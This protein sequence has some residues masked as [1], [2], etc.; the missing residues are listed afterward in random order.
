MII[1]DQQIIYTNKARCRDCFRCLRYCTVNAIKMKDGQAFV[2]IERCILCG[3]CI[4]ECPQNAKQFRRDLEKVKELIKE[5]MSIAV[6]IAPSFA[7]LF[8]DWQTDRIPSLLRKLGFTY[9][10]ETAESAYYTAIETEKY[11]S[12]KS[13]GICL[14]TA[15][16]SFVDYV[17]KYL[18]DKVNNL[19][20][21]V[22]PMIAHGRRIKEK[23]GNQT[24]VVFIGPC[25]AKKR[26]AERQE[27]NGIIDAVLTFTEVLEWIEEEKIDLKMLETS[28]FDE[29]V[30]GEARLYPLTGGMSK[31]ASLATDNLNTSVYSISGLERI[32]DA[33]SSFSTK[34]YP[35]LIEPLI[36]A[37]G[38]VNGPAQPKAENIF[39]RR[40]SVINYSK[41][42][43]CISL[44]IPECTINLST[45]FK[46]NAAVKETEF[47][48]EEI[49]QILDQ[50]GKL[51]ESDR[52][53]CGACGYLSCMENAKAI[54]MGMVEIDSCIPYTRRLVLFRFL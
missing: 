26:E 48:D 36:C 30:F 42:K 8:T 18:P 23:L 19:T 6:S 9:I 34:D 16:P 24:K 2:D 53:N 29:I 17:E 1:N 40:E 28:E 7:A 50:T 46:R 33:I 31:T 22:S 54:L 49:R 27:F 52:L 25:L 5:N 11:F 39:A 12:S 41:Q 14:T 43:Y 47:S 35:I 32:K 44:D 37:F 15:C 45:S 20:P 38:C 21:I 3:T 13:N 51:Q 10:S 4:K